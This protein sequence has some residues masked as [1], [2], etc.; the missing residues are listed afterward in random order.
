MD[1]LKAVQVYWFTLQLYVVYILKTLRM[2]TTS[3]SEVQGYG[4]QTFLWP[5][6][7]HSTTNNP[8]KKNE[9]FI[10]CVICWFFE[11]HRN[12]SFTN[13]ILRIEAFVCLFVFTYSAKNDLYINFHR[14]YYEITS[15]IK[16]TKERN[17]N[18][19]VCR[20]VFRERCVRV[21]YAFIPRTKYHIIWHC[22]SKVWIIVL[23]I[24]KHNR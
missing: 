9:S 18:V 7:P 24:F 6:M 15:A 20:T 21:N 13:I 3:E 2:Q 10:E 12:T 19:T 22:D 4:N 16:T 5:C 23:G 1:H 17:R 11:F 8:T 14:M